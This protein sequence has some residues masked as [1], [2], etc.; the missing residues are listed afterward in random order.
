MIKNLFF[1]CS[2]KS[3]YNN[4]ALLLFRVIVS[5]ALIYGHGYGKFMRLLDGNVWGRTH[6]FFSEEITFA[7]ITFAEFF[8]SIF[9][10]LGLGTRFFCVP[11]IYA[12]LVIVFDVHIEDPFTKMEKGVLFLTSF[13]TIFLMGPGKISL[14]HH[15]SK[16]IN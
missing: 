2:V 6:L 1:F 14:D 3:H 12:F 11:L 16:K 7:M 5:G 4:I 13:I 8:C 10:I 9:I 15:I